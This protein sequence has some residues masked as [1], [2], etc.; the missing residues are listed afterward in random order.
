VVETLTL[1]AV[2][3]YAFVAIRQWREMIQAR[4]QVERSVGQATIAAGAAKDSADTAKQTMYIDQRAWLSIRGFETNGVKDSRYEVNK[5]LMIRVVF[6]NTGKTP[7][8][9][10]RSLV[11]ETAVLTKG[12][13]PR[14]KPKWIRYPDKVSGTAMGNISTSTESGHPFADLLVTQSLSQSDYDLIVQNKAHIF[15]HGKVWYCDVFNYQHWFTFCGHMLSGGA[16]AVCDDGNEL[17]TDPKP[18]SCP[19]TQ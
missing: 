15:V 5:P 18:P 6:Q 12:T 2:I 7:A 13:V 8:L 19:V 10:V 17:D 11:Y 1:W 3:G 9:H 4:H 14:E 16:Y